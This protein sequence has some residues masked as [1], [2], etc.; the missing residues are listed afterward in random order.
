MTGGAVLIRLQNIILMKFH[1]S[2]FPSRLL[3][4]LPLTLLVQSCFFTGVE[5]TPRITGKDVRREVAPVTPEDTYLADV[6]DSPLSAW[7]RGKE[8]MVTDPRISRIFGATAPSQPLTGKIIRYDSAS[9]TTG[10]T[11][12]PV[13]DITFISPGDDRLVYRINRPLQRLMSETSTEIPFTIQM[14]VIAGAA[15]RLIGKKFYIL[16][17]SWRDDTDNPVGA[18]ANLSP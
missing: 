3:L 9:E 8:F 5:S 12:S 18:A 4:L 7:E 14:S 1:T 6:T 13:T 11:G 16:T 2:H 17:S 15:D 10:I